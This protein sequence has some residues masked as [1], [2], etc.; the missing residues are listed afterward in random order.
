MR[1]MKENAIEAI[2]TDRTLSVPER[3]ER[4][5]EALYSMPDHG[6]SQA[7]ETLCTTDDARV[8]AFVSDYLALLPDRYAEKSRAAERL[9]SVPEL[10]AAASRLVPW[11]T[12]VL[13]DKFIGDYRANPDKRSPLYSVMFEIA[14]FVPALLRPH[15]EIFDAPSIL[16]GLLSG[17]PD[18]WID[19]FKARWREGRD[20]D[21]LE[22]IARFRTRKAADTIDRFREEIGDQQRWECWLEMA[23]RLPDGS[24]STVTPSF[25]GFVVNL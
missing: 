10:A 17:G 12:P 22:S 25:L 5:T 18:A 11:L 8:A 15:R 6:V 9:R 4:L 19:D 23:G 3:T 20:F 7:V 21:A 1:S 16:R 2:A 24:L 14:T 13:L